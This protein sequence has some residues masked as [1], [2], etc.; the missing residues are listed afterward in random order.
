MEERDHN[1]SYGDWLGECREDPAGSGYG[2][3]EGSCE[4]GDE[5]AGSGAT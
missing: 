3:A 1:E 4:C 2:P 5:P